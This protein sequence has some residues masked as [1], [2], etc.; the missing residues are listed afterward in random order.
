[1]M[2]V[3]ALLWAAACE[4]EHRELR[5]PPSGASTTPAI[6]VSELVPGPSGVLPDSIPAG[7]EA[8]EHRQRA[9]CHGCL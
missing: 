7:P 8:G 1:M 5:T 6:R 9:A 2:L 4:R 3:G